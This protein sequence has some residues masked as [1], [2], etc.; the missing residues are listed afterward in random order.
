MENR[1]PTVLVPSKMEYCAKVVSII[2]LI[3]MQLTKKMDGLNKTQHLNQN[4]NIYL[5]RIFQIIWMF[6]SGNA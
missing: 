4:E 5:L 2:G 6:K 1:Q 3:M